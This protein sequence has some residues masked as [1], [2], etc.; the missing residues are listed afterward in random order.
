MTINTL[1]FG[2]SIAVGYDASYM[3]YSDDNGLRRFHTMGRSASWCCW[4]L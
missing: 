4:P 3:R 2:V 1:V